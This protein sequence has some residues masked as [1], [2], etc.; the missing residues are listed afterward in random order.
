MRP[1][2]AS[3]AHRL[4]GPGHDHLSDLSTELGTIHGSQIQVGGD[5]PKA[6]DPR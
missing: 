1:N 6:A 3:Q 4:P 2:P 5:P